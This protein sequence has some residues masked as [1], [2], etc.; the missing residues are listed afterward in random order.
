MAPAKSAANPQR[1]Y[2]SVD[3]ANRSLPLVRAIVDDIVRQTRLV[4]GLQQ[5]LQRVLRERRRPADDLYSEELAQTQS[6][7]EHR[8]T[9]RRPPAVDNNSGGRTN[10]EERQER[11]FQ[12]RPE[13]VKNS[14]GDT[15]VSDIR[16]V[17]EAVY[18]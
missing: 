12:G 7:L 15:G 8:S 6:E 10:R 17:E 13:G 9:D 14:E 4:D 16:N 18:N 11:G 3:E 1:K 5:R 2:F